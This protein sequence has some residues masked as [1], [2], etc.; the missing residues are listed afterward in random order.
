MN[1]QKKKWSVINNKKIN[2]K[3]S[4]I[5]TE[6]VFSNDDATEVV[7]FGFIPYSKHPLFSGGLMSVPDFENMRTTDRLDARRTFAATY[8]K[9]EFT[10]YCTKNSKRDKMYDC[11][12]IITEN[13]VWWGMV[14]NTKNTSGVDSNGLIS[15]SNFILEEVE[16]ED[17]DNPF[18]VIYSGP[19]VRANEDKDIKRM[20]IISD[21]F[22]GVHNIPHD[23]P[24]FLTRQRVASIAFFRS[25]DKGKAVIA[26]I[27][28][29]EL[30][31]FCSNKP[32]LASSV[33][34]SIALENTEEGDESWIS[35]PVLSIKRLAMVS[36]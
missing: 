6:I 22:G 28:K 14:S 2:D 4:L 27:K 10:T 35:H 12:N 29:S 25:G 21:E 20:K 9:F 23:H 19:L 8:H 24:F 3:E 30:S 11:V 33:S 16:D 32:D 15:A 36:R 5:E 17:S 34:P 13:G 26:S 18:C 31:K 1:K 7:T